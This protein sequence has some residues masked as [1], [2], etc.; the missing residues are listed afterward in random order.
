MTEFILTRW[1]AMELC[2]LSIGPIFYRVFAV[3]DFMYGSMRPSR[4]AGLDGCT[5][6][7]CGVGSNDAWN[8]N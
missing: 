8:G 2:Q 1:Q 7:T 6:P 4:K 3:Y 5:N